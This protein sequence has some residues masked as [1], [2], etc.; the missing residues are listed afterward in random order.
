MPNIEFEKETFIIEL[1]KALPVFSFNK[2]EF[3]P[4]FQNNKKEIALIKKGQVSLM[5][6]DING[7]LIYIDHFNR[8]Q[9]FSKLWIYNEENDLFL[10]CDSPT[11]ILFFDYTLFTQSTNPKL[12]TFF[13]EKSLQYMNYLN[14]KI[15]IL[16]KKSMEEKLMTYFKILSKKENSK[17]FEIPITYKDLADYLGV[18]R[19]SLMRKLNELEVKKKIQKKGRTI[20]LKS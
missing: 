15:T 10:V 1:T 9:M 13:L 8:Y 3:I 11:E 7:N 5:K 19:S 2:G 12:L 16:Q 20:F 4:I 14:Q 6:S 17:K 18:D